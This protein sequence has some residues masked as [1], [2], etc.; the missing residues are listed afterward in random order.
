M[1][2]GP[3]SS[4]H[5]WF[6]AR[7]FREL[8]DLEF[9]RSRGEWKRIEFQVQRKLQQNPLPGKRAKRMRDLYFLL[10]VRWVQAR[11]AQR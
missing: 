2:Y 6:R 1:N 7:R 3:F 8:F 5:D 10:C 4:V 11:W 9:P